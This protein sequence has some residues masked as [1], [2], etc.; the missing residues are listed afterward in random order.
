MSGVAVCGVLHVVIGSEVLRANLA[1]S[2]NEDQVSRRR[3]RAGS[4]QRV[5]R[6]CQ[7]TSE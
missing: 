3:D 6:D 7:V 5:A 4:T 1:V 2:Q